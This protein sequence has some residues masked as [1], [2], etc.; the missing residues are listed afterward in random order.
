[1]PEDARLRLEQ[2]DVGESRL[3]RESW[4]VCLPGEDKKRETAY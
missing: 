4:D 3:A 1:M 2:K